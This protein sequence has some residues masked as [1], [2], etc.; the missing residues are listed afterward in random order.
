MW[1]A[2]EVNFTEVQHGEMVPCRAT[3]VKVNYC[4]RPFAMPMLEGMLIFHGVFCKARARDEMI[5]LGKP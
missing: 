5:N 2:R 3:I 1:G 4:I